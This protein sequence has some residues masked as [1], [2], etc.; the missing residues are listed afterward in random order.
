MVGVPSLARCDLRAVLADRL[1]LALLDAQ[2]VDDGRAEQEHEQQRRHDGAAGAEGDVAKDVERPDLIAE[3]H[4]R[5]EHPSTLQAAAG[6]NRVSMAST[7]GAMRVPSEP[8]II[9]TSPGAHGVEQAGHQL[10]RGRRPGAAL[11]G[12][13]VVEQQ[14]HHRT[15]GKNQI[16]AG[17]VNRLLQAAVQLGRRF[18]QLQ[19]VAQHGDAA[20]ESL[21]RRR[22]HGRQ[23]GAHGGRIGVVA[24]VDQQDLARRRHRA[25]CARRGRRVRRCAPAPAGSAWHRRRARR[26]P[27]ARPASSARSARRARRS[28]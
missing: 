6:P 23:R 28:R 1:A 21:A 18:A 26:A 11:R 9:T 5:V 17:R 27:P 3:V 10:R 15:T 20:R 2:Q 13:Q 16:D 8:L 22:R 19:H 12:R 24:L 4:Q 7:S 25:A 14:L